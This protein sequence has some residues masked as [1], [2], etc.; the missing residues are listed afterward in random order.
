M[1]DWVSEGRSAR[2]ESWAFGSWKGKNEV[3]LV[4]EAETSSQAPSKEGEKKRRLLLRDNVVLSGPQ[5]KARMESFGLFGTLILVGPLLQPLADFMC[6]EFD[7]LPRLGGRN[8]DTDS[9]TTAPKLE[10]REK[11]RMERQAREKRDG[12]IWTVAKV[13]GGKATVVKFGAADVE[14]GREWLGAMLKMEGT[15]GRE[16]GPG[17]LMGVS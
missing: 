1:L 6:S 9:S 13:R 3:W 7:A 4:P 17:G 2:Q 16:F 5:I 14:G 12:L 8:W 15:V 10:A 11:W